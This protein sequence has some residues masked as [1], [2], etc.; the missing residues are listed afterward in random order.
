MKITIYATFEEYTQLKD[1]FIQQTIIKV[2]DTEYIIKGLTF[3]VGKWISR[4]TTQRVDLYL[5]KV[6]K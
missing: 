6:K 3:D 5:E 2:F 1:K 4:E